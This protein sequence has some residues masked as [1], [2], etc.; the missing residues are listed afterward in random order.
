M[1][2]ERSGQDVEAVREF[3]NQ[4]AFYR[5]IVDLNYLSHAEAMPALRGWLAG[6]AGAFAFM[7]LGCGDAYYTTQMLAGLP[8]SRYR[9]VDLS[10]VALEL[11]ERN[12]AALGCPFTAHCGDFADEAR[13][14]GDA[15]DVIYVGL[16]FHHLPKAAKAEFCQNVR[17]RLLPGGAFVFFEP[18]LREGES[19]DA[20][21]VRWMDHARRVWTRLDADDMM[22]V[23]D[24]VTKYDFPETRATYAV[25]A[26]GAGFE[27]ADTIFEDPTGFYAITVC[28]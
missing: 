5:R 17:A 10:P 23:E 16:S 20:Y 4:W 26:L 21:L 11:A 28:S 27:K 25:M 14:E 13:A 8:L 9:A 18:F 12:A 15:F 7:D 22:A 19:R 2:P 6:R 3:F 1:L 24:H